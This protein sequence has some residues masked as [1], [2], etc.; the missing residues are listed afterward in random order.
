LI[1][2]DPQFA[3][4]RHGIESFGAIVLMIEIPARDSGTRFLISMLGAITMQTRVG[5]M[6]L[7]PLFTSMLT[8]VARAQTGM[9]ATAGDDSGWIPLLAVVIGA[10]FAVLVFWG[11]TQG[12]AAFFSDSQITSERRRVL[13][14]IGLNF[15]E[16]SLTSGLMMFAFVRVQGATNNVLFL[17]FCLPLVSFLSLLIPLSD[18]LGFSSQNQLEQ[19]AYQNLRKVALARLIGVLITASSLLIMQLWFAILS[20]AIGVLVFGWSLQQLSKQVDLLWPIKPETRTQG[21][22]NP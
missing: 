10:C 7:I 20:G 3:V 11:F 9:A 6:L 19:S 1:I 22:S 15:L 14:W 21:Q 18:R 8:C 4:F 12:L 13:R 5:Q 17:W 2:G 16:P